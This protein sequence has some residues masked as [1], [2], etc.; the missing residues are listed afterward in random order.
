MY[1]PV[2]D[3]KFVRIDSTH[4]FETPIIQSRQ[5]LLL[6]IGMMYLGSSSCADIESP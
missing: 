6:S 3:G 5:V 4:P 1:V 2:H